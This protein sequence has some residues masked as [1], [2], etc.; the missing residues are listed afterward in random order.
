MASNEKF[1]QFVKKIDTQMIIFK[2][3]GAWF[4]NKMCIDDV[5]PTK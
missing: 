4:R 3:C 1:M 2:I 5:Q